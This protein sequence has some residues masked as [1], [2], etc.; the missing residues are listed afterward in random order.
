MSEPSEIQQNNPNPAW[1]RVYKSW[2]SFIIVLIVMLV[3]FSEAWWIIFPIIGSFFTAIEVTVDYMNK[4][5]SV[6]TQEKILPQEKVN[7]EPQK[8][9]LEQS[10]PSSIAP[11]SES[12]APEAKFCSACGAELK[13]NQITCTICGSETK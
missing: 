13:L 9:T 12:P 5:V 6:D 1:K 3:L 4:R 11:I 7:M 2:V 10:I 8:A